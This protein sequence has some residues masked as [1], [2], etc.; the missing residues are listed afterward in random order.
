MAKVTDERDVTAV[1]NLRAL[2]ANKVCNLDDMDGCPKIQRLSALKT[3]PNSGPGRYR[4]GSKCLLNKQENLYSNP[5]NPCKKSGVH[6]HA[7]SPSAVGAEGEGRL[8]L[9]LLTA[10]MV[11]VSMREPFSANKRREID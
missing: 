9:F 6:R 10:S 7:Y 2:Y 3:S 5:Q 11:P 8:E 1:G 4:T